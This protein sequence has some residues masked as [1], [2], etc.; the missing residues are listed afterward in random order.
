MVVARWH[1]QCSTVKEL[2]DKRHHGSQTVIAHLEQQTGRKGP[3]SHSCCAVRTSPCRF[4]RPI[5]KRAGESADRLE[6]PT[7][8]DFNGI[9][10]A[11]HF[12]L[13][14]EPDRSATDKG[15]VRKHDEDGPTSYF[16]VCLTTGHVPI[17][18]GSSS[19]RRRRWRQQQARWWLPSGSPGLSLLFR[20]A[21]LSRLNCRPDEEG[22]R[23]DLARALGA[24]VLAARLG[25]RPST[26]REASS[27]LVPMP[28]AGQQSCR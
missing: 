22:S 8:K 5:H 12:R 14:P 19:H 16:F 11:P 20:L 6:R 23:P 28:P 15:E 26:Q 21:C 7:G 18:H 17:D 2:R 10:S 3:C 24:R 1:S 27:A 4:A 13:A 25:H 9:M